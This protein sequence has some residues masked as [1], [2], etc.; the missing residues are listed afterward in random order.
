[1]RWK[2]LVLVSL[3]TALIASAIWFL[4]ITVF[5]NGS[6]SVLQI[7]GDF[8]PLTTI[9][10]FLLALLGGVFVYRH[11]SR[12]RK[13][14]AAI[15]VLAAATL[16]ALVCFTVTSLLRQRAAISCFPR[17]V[18]LASAPTQSLSAPASAHQSQIEHAHPTRRLI[19]ELPGGY[20][21]DLPNG[22]SVCPSTSS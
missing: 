10:P 16:T 7:N 22:Q 14:Q 18:R 6:S 21:R 20:R 3:V 11:T 8:W 12:R 1:M 4:L 17:R 19:P 15:T 13:T 2:L 9:L 5:F